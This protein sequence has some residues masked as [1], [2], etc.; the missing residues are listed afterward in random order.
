[1]KTKGLIII[2]LLIATIS[3]AQNVDISGFA[4]TYEGVTYEN[5][6]FAMMQQTLNL[7]FEKRGEK[8]A[9]KANPMLYLYNSDSLYFQMREIYVDMY[10]QNFDLRIGKQQVVWGKADGVF[11]TDIVSPLNLTEFLLPDFDEI[12]IGVIAAKLN[13]Y[14]GN[15]T[16]E[17]IWI[18]QFTPTTRPAASSIWYI[19]PTF[20]APPQF[21]WSQSTINPSLANSE[22]FL[23]YSAMTSKVDFEIMGGYTW[24]DNPTMH[25]QKEMTVDSST[26]PPTP[27]LNGLII[28]PK[29]HRLTVGG[30][31]FSTEIKGVILRGEAAYYN[32]KY[33]QTTDPMATDALIQKDYLHYVAG[34]DFNLGSVKL[35]TQFIQQY[36]LDHNDF[37]E[38]KEALNT[39]TFLVHY[40]MLRETLHLELFSYIGLSNSDALIRPKITYD[41]DDSFSVLFGGNIFVGDKQGQFGQY[42]DNSMAYAKIKYNF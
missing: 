35:S 22:F 8:V 9:L 36:I 10:F 33:F 7:N 29:H 25:I 16:I 5:G 38:Q 6:D 17:A 39:A 21:D 23:K 37:M 27:S 2:A 14:I 34:V 42:S 4:R 15:G 20:P 1:M 19:Q 40:D 24:D 30:G 18:P 28:T 3:Q 31:S 11:I 12:R 32:G 13:Y 26:M 41:F